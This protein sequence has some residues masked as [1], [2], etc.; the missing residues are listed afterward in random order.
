MIIVSQEKN[1]IINFDNIL[2]I[3]ITIDEDDKGCYIQYEDCNNS[4][5]GLGK[6]NTEKRAKKVLAEIVRK[7]SS[8]LQLTGRPAIMQGQMDIQPNIF[9]IPK[10]YEMPED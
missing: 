1:R 9:N 5:E 4:C 8:Y 3:Y 6:Y 2:Q 7:Y 10:T